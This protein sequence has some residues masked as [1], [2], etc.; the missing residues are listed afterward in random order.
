MVKFLI[1]RPIAVFMTTLVFIMLGL[2]AMLNI[3]SA[4]MPDIPIPEITVKLS[5]PNTSARDLE[6]NITRPLRN[7]LLQVSNL[8][9][10]QTET[11]DGFATFKLYFDYGTNTDFAFIETNEKID[12]SLNQLPRNLDRPKVIKA[13]ATDIPI[14]N[15]TVTP[16]ERGSEKEY[17][18]LSEFTETVLK[19]R[20]EQ[21]P[22]IALADISG[23]T[24]P[25][26]LIEPR[27]KLLQSLGIRN[28]DLIT[29]IEENNFE[30]GNL[31]VQNGI[32]QYYFKFS[33]PLR[34]I[35]DLSNIQLNINGKLFKLKEL[36]NIEMATMQKRGSVI[37]NG[38]EAILIA[39][40]KQ[41]DTKVE[42]LKESLDN[43]LVNFSTDYP[44]L[45]FDSHQDQSELLELSLNNLKSSLLIGS[46]LAILII[47]FFL[48]DIKLP[49]IIGLSIPISLVISV[50]FMYIFGLSINIISLSGLILGVG[51]MID[52][53]IIIIDN[54]TQKLE[55]GE[56]Y[57]QACIIGTTEMISPLISSIL[58]TCMI[59]LPLLFL[60]GI[61]G[62][63]FY[64]QALAVSIG[65][66]SSLLVSVMLIPVLY[67]ELKIR[68]IKG[69]KS[70]QFHF[71]TQEIE[72]WYEKGFDFF[73][74]RIYI[75]WTTAI[76]FFGLGILLFLLLPYSKLPEFSQSETIFEI[77]WNESINTTENEKRIIDLLE[78]EEGAQTYISKVGEQQFLMDQDEVQDFS[79]SSTYIKT[80]SPTDLKSLKD[81]LIERLKEYPNSTYHFLPPSNIFEYLFG[82]ET[83]DLVAEVY[84]KNKI[85]IPAPQDL[86]KINNLLPTSSPQALQEFVSISIIFERLLLYNVSLTSLVSVLNTT[87]G[88]NFI[89]DLKAE[90]RYIPIKLNYQIKNLGKALESMLVE[91]EQGSLIPVKNLITVR[92]T[93]HYKFIKGDKSGEYLGYSV[94]TNNN[95]NQNLIEKTQDNFNQSSFYGVRFSGNWFEMENLGNE[96]LVVIGV[97]IFLLYFIMAAQF[98]SL[99]QPIIILLEIP[100][101]IGGGLLLLWLFGGTINI[102]AAIGIVVMSGIVI[103]DS[104]IKIHTINLLRK[105]GLPVIEAI[106]EGGRLRLKP[107][108]MTS[109]TTIFALMPFLFISGLGAELQLPLALTVIGGMIIG[110]FISLYFLPFMYYYLIKN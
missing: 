12:A 54:I 105:Q 40:I 50:F 36:A 79:E 43:L 44:Q 16:K 85:E 48:K 11:R 4:L 22:D 96:L 107:I 5:H 59:F 35:S 82:S 110:T 13:S 95:N 88:Q 80:P 83:S 86:N 101:D 52:N 37:Y 21:L 57:F 53:A 45:N 24:R 46:L 108:V 87:F 72:D 93:T 98:E 31:I 61:T 41:S 94:N 18:E 33:D 58:T 15:I 34:T 32:Y 65:L 51:M 62:A 47:F 84:S 20:I 19:K 103:N 64:D 23:L 3:P 6:T 1:N 9:D 71:K 27:S 100:I 104:I 17:L 60:S 55:S 29:A 10:I 92:P 91:N 49:I 7:Q 70:L 81:K 66:G 42:D 89:G 77:N 25:E 67:H 73:F 74:K 78:N 75:I 102:M 2:V 28:E 39:V 69:R 38:K 90:Q 56:S 97:A 99:L 106:K 30:M 26:V 68:E 109:L 76:V 14:L 8:R 63:L